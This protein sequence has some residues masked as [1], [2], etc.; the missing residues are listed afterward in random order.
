[1]KLPFLAL[2]LL[3]L[4]SG[5][6]RHETTA[7]AAA[8]PPVRVHLAPVQAEM[9]PHFTEV[10]GTIR[11]V[12]RAVL[13][14]KVMGAI[15]HLPVAL[16][17]QVQQDEIL[18]KLYSAEAAARVTQARAQLNV[19]ERDYE[20]EHALLQRG[21]STAESVRTLQDRLTGCTAALREAE[22]Q[23][24]YTEIRAPFAGVIARKPVQ[25]GDLA[26][27]G[28]PLLEL[29]GTSAFEIEACIPDSLAGALQSGALFACDVGGPNFAGSLREISSSTDPATRSIGVKIA[30]PA[31]ASVRSGQFTR[32]QVPG[33]LHSA[34][35]VPSSAVSV[36]GQLERVFVVGAGK[37][38]VLRLVKTGPQLGDRTEI[39]AGLTASDLVV[40]D[41]PASL[42]DGQPLEEAP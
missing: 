4:A 9:L 35:L 1:M 34:L 22:T 17:Q 14:A 2:S 18:V 41:P 3:V 33:S 30:V 32:I 19:A 7:A 38:A 36:R 5:C 25:S 10:T 28:Q 23:L 15:T 6:S 13:A 27:P 21:A 42:R 37:K 8:L 11:P 20:R 12:H 16:G 29:E 39:L 26:V 24:G 40:V 31:D